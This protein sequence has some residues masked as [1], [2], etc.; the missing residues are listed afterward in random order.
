MP[1]EINSISNPRLR[2]EILSPAEIERI[3]STTLDIMEKVVCGVVRILEN[4]KDALPC[5]MPVPKVTH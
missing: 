3:H 1:N 2:L 4:H 5:A